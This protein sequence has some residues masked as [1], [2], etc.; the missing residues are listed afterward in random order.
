MKKSLF[1]IICLSFAINKIL[2]YEIQ[3]RGDSAVK[4]DRVIYDTTLSISG[5]TYNWS[6]NNYVCAGGDGPFGAIRGV[7][8]TVQD[9][10]V[11]V[12]ITSPYS[13][14]TVKGFRKGYTVQE[15]VDNPSVSGSTLVC[16]SGAAFTLNAIPPNNWVTWESSSNLYT[17]NNTTNPCTF[18]ATS[19][20]SGWIKP[21]L[22]SP[23][24]ES[25][26]NNYTVWAGKPVLYVFLDPMKDM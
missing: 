3:I 18:I 17:T 22:N 12:E 6:G 1:I 14:T 4:I 20:G 24:C 9:G 13:N 10:E 11:F 15:K 21:I 23:G 25:P 19:D 2:Y 7:T 16:S 5:G 26:L 8:E